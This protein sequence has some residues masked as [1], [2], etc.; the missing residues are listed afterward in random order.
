LVVPY[1]NQSRQ[2]PTSEMMYPAF[3]SVL[4]AANNAV[5]TSDRI[6]KVFVVMALSDIDCSPRTR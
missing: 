3:A 2:M 4:I 5:A 1:W 6:V